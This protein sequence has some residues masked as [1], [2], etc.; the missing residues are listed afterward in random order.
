MFNIN[1]KKIALAFFSFLIIGLGQLTINKVYALTVNVVEPT[2]NCNPANNTCDITF[3]AVWSG[4]QAG[5]SQMFLDY[6][7]VR[8]G[9]STLAEEHRVEDGDDGSFPVLRTV[10]V[11]TLG[12]SDVNYIVSIKCET[13][14]EPN[15]DACPTG[16]D[17]DPNSLW[18]HSYNPNTLVHAYSRGWTIPFDGRLSMDLNVESNYCDIDADSITTRAN[19]QWA[20]YYTAGGELRLNLV[21]KNKF[22][23]SIGTDN[24]RETAVNSAPSGNE[25][26]WTDSDIPLE[27][28]S[29]P[30]TFV[31]TFSCD[32]SPQVCTGFTD[33]IVVTTQCE[34]V[35]VNDFFMDTQLNLN[36][37]T[38]NC[39][40]PT[41]PIPF[42]PT[43]SWYGNEDQN[44]PAMTPFK[45]DY[46]AEVSWT[47]NGGA[48][49]SGFVSNAGNS[50]SPE[51]TNVPLN[52]SAD[53]DFQP[54]TTL[55]VLSRI[56][57]SPLNS[58]YTCPPPVER[59][60][61]C[62]IGQPGSIFDPDGPA[63]ARLDFGLNFGDA[64]FEGVTRTIYRIMYPLALAFGAGYIVKAGYTLAT[65]QNNPNLIQQGKDDLTAAI[66]GMLFIML[67][68]TTLR[69]IINLL[70]GPA[71]I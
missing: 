33:P 71:T 20:N 61:S 1:S 45:L 36:P 48:P 2:L 66:T 60:G 49:G 21:V 3:N 4:G 30:I 50:E 19:I 13:T 25:Y 18:T 5:A 46:Y 54:D 12:G 35:A 59:T 52:L 24:Y 53:Y 43:F 28:E 11:P 29:L 15:F 42:N 64:T 27:P 56:T 57:C 37:I 67:S 58:N 70:L 62:V 26:T 23:G 17:E 65:S 38:Q 40:S 9:G 34:T 32:D 55:S 6:F 68:M 39:E 14:L 47:R 7:L 63:L 10:N 51:G 41:G 44:N 8:T 69:I 16:T 22:G 31:W